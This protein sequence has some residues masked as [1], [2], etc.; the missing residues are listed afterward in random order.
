MVEK[1][2]KV[3]AEKVKQ[4]GGRTF[5][6]GGY[7]RDKLLGIDNKDVD[8]EV[9]G[10]D[11][12]KLYSI[13]ERIE[14]PLT[15]GNSF[16]IYSLKGH[17][18]DIALPRSEKCIGNKHTDFRIDVD[19]FIGYKKAAKRRDITINALMQ[20]V[21]TD[22]ILD[23]YNGL[24]DLKNKIIRHVDDESFIEDPL[25]VL[26]IAQFASR[27]EFTVAEETINLCKT[28]DLTTLSRERI[29]EELRK[30]LLKG[31]KPSIFFD[32]LKE[33]N[34]LDYW[35]KEIKELENIPQDPI[36]HPEG[37]VYIHTMQ[38]IDRGVKYNP[39]FEFMLLCLTHDFGKIVCTTVDSS[40]RFESSDSSPA[41]SSPIDSHP[42]RI[43]SYGHE[44]EG[45]PIIETFIKRITNKK[46]IIKYLKNM[47]P[48]HMAPNKYAAD[49]S[50]I[51][52]TNKMFYDAYNE[53]DL[54]NFSYC[55]RGNENNKEF[56]M[57]RYNHY[58]EMMKKPYVSGDDLIEAGFIPDDKF[59]KLIE[60][61][62]KLRMAEV[63]K[64]NALKQIKSY[65]LS[66]LL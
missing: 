16:G 9:H 54:I 1:I 43:H 17:N 6:V 59:K 44:I 48:L 21:L 64:D 20:D 5:Y 27:F 39:S 7:V 58:L 22:E 31:K 24:D 4:E 65:Y 30:A 26:R 46:D 8:I 35:F 49:K 38:V 37:N 61:A 10:I 47:V 36:Y 45:L 32:V 28:M 12:D 11:A 34:Q 41:D 60:Y 56:L 33:M 55:D 62:T 50:A 63:D 18:I 57:E 23:Y 42:I 13:L 15:Y 19:P 52:K 53:I 14:K 51:K 29:E 25:R 66:N 3:I 40:P 2:E